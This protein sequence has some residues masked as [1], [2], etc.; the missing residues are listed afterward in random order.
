MQMQGSRC[1][2]EGC[3]VKLSLSAFAC[4]CDKKFCSAHRPS[5]MHSC[6]YDYKGEQSKNLLNHMSTVVAKKIDII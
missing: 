4:R 3:K 1:N 6:A 2:Y 5:E